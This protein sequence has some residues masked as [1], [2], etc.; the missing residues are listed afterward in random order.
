MQ[1]RR[2]KAGPRNSA[3]RQTQDE[4]TEHGDDRPAGP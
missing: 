1:V 2:P 4:I 3:K